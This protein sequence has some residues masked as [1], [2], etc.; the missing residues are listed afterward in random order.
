[1]PFCP[2]CK[3]EYL[4]SVETCPDC[5]VDLV[6]VLPIEQVEMIDWVPVYQA[7]TEIAANMVQGILNSRNLQSSIRRNVVPGYVIPASW[8]DAY[9]GEILVPQEVAEQAKEIVQEYLDGL[10]YDENDQNS[11]TSEPS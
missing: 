6:P 9:W 11:Q 10:P 3:A 4:D 7:P 2:R 1:M 8:Y 5:Q